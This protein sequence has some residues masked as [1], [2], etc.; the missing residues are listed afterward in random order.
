MPKHADEWLLGLQHAKKRRPHDKSV[1]KA[2]INPVAQNCKTPAI[3][4]VIRIS[5]R[6]ANPPS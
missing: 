2:E 3:E 1:Q 6:S 5:N 4:Q